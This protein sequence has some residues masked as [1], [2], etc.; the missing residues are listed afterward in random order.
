MGFIECARRL[1]LALGQDANGRGAYDDIVTRNL[2]AIAR[3][4]ENDAECER[5][6]YECG[7]FY[8]LRGH[9]DD[10]RAAWADAMVAR[11]RMEAAEEM[12]AAARCALA[13]AKVG[14]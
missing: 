7:R 13:A 14:P 6:T 8:A 5:G 9:A 4:C 11:E 3:S 12:A 1:R 10:R 2:R